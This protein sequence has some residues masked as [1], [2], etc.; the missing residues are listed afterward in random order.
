M[1]NKVL[2][3]GLAA[4]IPEKTKTVTKASLEI[5]NID[6]GQIKSS[7]YQPRESF[8][9]DKLTD[10]VASIKEKGILQPL[11]VRKTSGGYEL[12]A[13]ERRLRAAKILKL[14]QVP[15]II[16]D[17]DNKGSL[18]LSIIENI[19]REQ[20][21]AIEE[22]HAFKR[23][24]NEFNLSQEDVG[25]AVGKD[26]VTVSNTLRLLNL[27]KEIQEQVSKGKITQGHAR[28]LLALGET[29]EQIEFFEKILKDSL[30]VRELERLIQ[31]SPKRKKSSQALAAKRARKDPHVLAVEEELQHKIGSKVRININKKNKGTIAIE[32][33]NLED[34]ERIVELLKK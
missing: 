12:I 18:V 9:D 11:I 1:V 20:L 15:A 13:G 5:D 7:S 19:Q 6:I 8:A 25:K 4:L 3:R 24:I 26:R 31:E 28:A 27:P 14:P 32:F 21:N 17:V 10:L 29:K 23:L 33:Y 22:A 2:G 34:L 30:S 16:K